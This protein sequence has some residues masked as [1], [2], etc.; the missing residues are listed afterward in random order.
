MWT[1]SFHRSFIELREPLSLSLLLKTKCD[2]E[3]DS[4]SLKTYDILYFEIH[5]GF[6]KDPLETDLFFEL[7]FNNRLGIYVN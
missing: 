5:R 2:H 6:A 3:I 7:V 4:A 1:F